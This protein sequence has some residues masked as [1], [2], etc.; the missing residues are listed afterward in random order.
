M[1]IFG[2]RD[3]R[4]VKRLL[5]ETQA[6]VER[7]TKPLGDVGLAIVKASHTCSEALKPKFKIADAK[8]KQQ[9]EIY[10]L[11]EFIYFF[12]HLTMRSACN[13][14]TEQQLSSAL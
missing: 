12:M 9:A 2:S 4:E 14:L 1:S 8:E 6:E 11:Y 5:K 3:E 13:Q 7:T 10:V